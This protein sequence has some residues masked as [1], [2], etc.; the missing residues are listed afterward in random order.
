M[1]YCQGLRRSSPCTAGY[2]EEAQLRAWE[3]AADVRLATSLLREIQEWTTKEKVDQERTA[4][5]KADQATEVKEKTDRAANEKPRME[6]HGSAPGKVV[7]MRKKKAK[8][9]E[10][11]EAERK[12]KKKKKKKKVK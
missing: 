5:E 8:E 9:E 11:E 10:E 3:A 7:G 2:R 1:G 4:N 12:K 6:L